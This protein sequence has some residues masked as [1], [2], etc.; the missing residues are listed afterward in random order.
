MKALEELWSGCEAILLDFDGVLADSEPFY[1]RSWNRV[2]SR[3]NHSVGKED[4]WKYWAYLGQGLEGEMERTGLLVPSPDEAKAEQKKIYAEFCHSGVIKPFPG[5]EKLLSAIIKLKPCAIA[6]NTSSDLIRCIT[7]RWGAAVPTI[8]GGEGLR[9]KPC[10]DIYLKASELLSV[11]PS[12]CL[13]IEDAMKGVIAGREAGM[14]VI[15][16]R[17]GYNDPFDA[18]GASGESRGLMPL[19]EIVEGS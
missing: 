17:N 11:K 8:V 13:V 10:P 6:S 3:W 12:R 7:S 18:N 16:V 15:L 9:S 5:A 4:Y 14:K 2:L 1:R 19:V